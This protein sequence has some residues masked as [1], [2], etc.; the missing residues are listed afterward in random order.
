MTLQME[1]KMLSEIRTMA[2]MDKTTIAE[3]YHVPL[4]VADDYFKT[5]TTAVLDVVIDGLDAEI[6]AQDMQKHYKGSV[7]DSMAKV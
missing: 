7:T 2:S 6:E 5:K 1:K 4:D 3:T